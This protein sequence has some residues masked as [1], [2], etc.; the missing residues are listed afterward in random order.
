MALQTIWK[1]AATVCGLMMATLS[2]VG[3]HAAAQTAGDGQREEEMLGTGQ[4]PAEHAGPPASRDAVAYWFGSNYRTPFVVVPATGKAAAIPRNAIEYT[5]ASFWSL[6]STFADVMVNQSSMAEP[7]AGGGTGATELYATLRSDVGL[8]GATGLAAFGR[9]PLRD[10]A[11]ELG[12]N[13]ETKNSSYAPGERT[14]YFGPKFQFA[15]PRGYLNVGIHV[16]K[17]WNHEGVLGKSEDYDPDFNIEPTWL[18]PFKVG[19]AHLAYTGFADYNTQKGKDSFGSATAPEFLVRNYVALDVG[20]LLLHRPQVLDLNGG[21]WYW[22]NE[23]GKPASV[24]GA[25]QM[26]PLVGMAFHFEGV[27]RSRGR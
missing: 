15:V 13:L 26:T 11:L 16:R 5:H 8:K 20:G 24:P 9:G 12:A 3:A 22:H 19:K 21:F 6:G 18:L 27:R 10:I 2:G 7:A 17:E 25:S 14:L 4:R 23:Y 1:D